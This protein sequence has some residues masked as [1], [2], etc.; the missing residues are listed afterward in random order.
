MCGREINQRIALLLVGLAIAIPAHAQGKHKVIIDEDCSG[1]GGTNMQAVLTL[2][3]SPETDVLGITI[4]TGDAWRD[5]EVQHALRLLEIIGRTDIPGGS[6]SR[7][8]RNIRNNLLGLA[9][10]TRVFPGHGPATSVEQE[11]RSNPF[12]K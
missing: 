11:A 3:N 8:L 7:L 2:V 6:A 12:F 5:E 4:P 9:K 1:P 10:I